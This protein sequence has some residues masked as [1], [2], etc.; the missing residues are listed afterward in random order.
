MT[1]FPNALAEEIWRSRYRFHPV[2]DAPEPSIDATWA[3]VARALASVERTDRPAWERRFANALA[4]YRFLPG[5]RILAGAGTGRRVTLF[6]CFVMGQIDDSMDG[7]FTALREGAL[8]LQQGGGIGYDF[9]PLRPAGEE[10]E[11]DERLGDR[12]VDRGVL[13]RDDQVVGHPA[14][15]EAGLLGGDRARREPL[16]LEALAVV[17]QDQAEVERHVADGIA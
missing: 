1:V 17:R 12:A 7:I 6:N 4:D 11:R 15:I 3:R 5:G 14:G 8:T 10:A 2:G 16:R 9:S 13:V